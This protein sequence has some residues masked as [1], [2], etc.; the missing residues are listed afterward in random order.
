MERGPAA[1]GLFYGDC[2][3]HCFVYRACRLSASASSEQAHLTDNYPGCKADEA[4]GLCRFLCCKK[5]FMKPPYLSSFSFVV[6]RCDWDRLRVD[7]LA[8]Y[9]FNALLLKRTKLEGIKAKA[10]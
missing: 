9:E 1:A 6:S 3:F 2:A 10:Q 4:A 7:R 5:H 8:G